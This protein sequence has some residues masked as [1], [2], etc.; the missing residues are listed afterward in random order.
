[1]DIAGAKGVG[2]LAK[3]GR[4]QQSRQRNNHCRPGLA[5]L[6]HLRALRCNRQDAG[7][8]SR[9]SPPRTSNRPSELP[10]SGGEVSGEPSSRTHNGYSPPHRADQGRLSEAVSDLSGREVKAFGGTTSAAQR[11]LSVTTPWGTCGKTKRR[12]ATCSESSRVKITPT[13]RCGGW[14]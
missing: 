2:C 10:P 4:S 7:S 9:L 12:S 13:L 6:T 3:C 8:N 14:P 11:L 5:R 1:M